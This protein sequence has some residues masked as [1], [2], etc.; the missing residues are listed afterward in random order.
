MQGPIS[1]PSPLPHLLP[2]RGELP[3]APS[4]HICPP[5]TRFSGQCL[6]RCRN[7]PGPWLRPLPGLS[8]DPGLVKDFAPSSSL[9]FLPCQVSFLLAFPQQHTKHVLIQRS[10]SGGLWRPERLVTAV[11]IGLVV[12]KKTKTIQKASLEF[13]SPLVS[14][15]KCL[16]GVFRPSVSTSLLRSPS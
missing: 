5:C 6:L 10:P 8:L 1:P 15:H 12:F 9:Y 4:H 7:S 14:L 2:G 3:H 13:M 11:L 16:R